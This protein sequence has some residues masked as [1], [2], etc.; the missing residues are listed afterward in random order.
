VKVIDGG[1][2][3]ERA[4]SYYAQLKI[5]KLQDMYR[6]EL[7]S[8]MYKFN[9]KQTPSSFFS[10]QYF[11]EIN[12]VYSKQTRSSTTQNYFIPRYETNKLQRSI[13]YQG[14][15]LWNSFRKEIKIYFVFN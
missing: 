6:L 2:W 1:R 3:R 10:N 12:K 4:S 11:K 13:K 5:L 15:K 7:A 8:F 9:K 14:S